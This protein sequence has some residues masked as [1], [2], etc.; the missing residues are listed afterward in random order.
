MN[1]TPA[2]ASQAPGSQQNKSKNDNNFDGYLIFDFHEFQGL[3]SQPDSNMNDD[4][5]PTDSKQRNT[6]IQNG[7][8]S[9]STV[10]KYQSQQENVR[11]FSVYN[12]VAEDQEDDKKSP[13][14]HIQNLD[15]LDK[16]KDKTNYDEFY[17]FLMSLDF[18]NIS[19]TRNRVD[20]ILMS[21]F[22]SLLKIKEYF[23]MLKN[24]IEKI[25][26]NDS[27]LWFDELKN[28]FKL[29]LHQFEN[30][31]N[32]ISEQINPVSLSV[33]FF[34]CIEYIKFFEQFLH[35]RTFHQQSTKGQN[36]P[37]QKFKR[38]VKICLLWKKLTGQKTFEQFIKYLDSDP[39]NCEK[40][41][42]CKKDI[43]N[44]KLQSLQQNLQAAAENRSS[45]NQNVQN[46]ENQSG[47]NP[48]NNQVSSFQT[49]ILGGINLA[50]NSNNN[51]NNTNNQQQLNNNVQFYH[52]S[53]IFKD[54]QDGFSRMLEKELTN[55][56][57]SFK[58]IIQ[59]QALQQN[60][61]K[62]NQPQQ[63]AVEYQLANRGNRFR[64]I[65]SPVQNSLYHK[66]DFF[67]S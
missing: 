21:Q 41:E 64:K 51:S 53:K 7:M 40:C 66:A 18:L 10:Q 1:Q 27:D 23:V 15:L 47:Q 5:S 61:Q 2:T 54:L 50:N 33:C 56:K 35:M 31:I 59:Q 58:K 57:K 60:Q 65:H 34:R 8:N 36:T 39:F 6:M 62:N 30:M 29:M 52:N 37:Q 4:R 55:T 22:E 3:I 14:L 19:N 44:Q 11:K 63:L 17:T 24:Y 67:M 25:T 28:T 12:N 9:S 43:K 46:Q 38:S 48:S 42:K 45:L 49:N 16:T 13:T 26:E 32:S 20:P